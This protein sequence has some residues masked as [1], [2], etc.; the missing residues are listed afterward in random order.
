MDIF[1]LIV[2]LI[3]IVAGTFWVG[4]AF[5]LAGFLDPLSKAL[6]PEGP[7]FMQRLMQ[8]RFPVV[9]AVAGVLNVV[10][11]LLLYY[12]DSG[13]LQAAW[14]A[15][16]PGLGFTAGGL[17]ALMALIYGGVVTGPTGAKL[18]RLGQ[19]IQSAGK[20]PTTE[21]LQQIEGYQR[22]LSQASV[23][24]TVLVGIAVVA[25]AVARYL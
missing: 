5:T 8:G 2:R 1:M 15:S 22:Q 9:I 16:G 19:E 24:N 7:R 18:G 14:M 11:G 6:M 23:V 3:H 17:A 21:Q 10:T 4:A 13:G 12:R 20:P 25:M